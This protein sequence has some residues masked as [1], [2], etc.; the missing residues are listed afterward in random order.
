MNISV[1]KGFKYNPFQTDKY[2]C[3]WDMRG[4]KQGETF[5]TMGDV[6]VTIKK[7]SMITWK[8]WKSKTK[9]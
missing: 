4:Y 6:I 1:W 7:T 9:L 8:T 5:T 3:I 2:M